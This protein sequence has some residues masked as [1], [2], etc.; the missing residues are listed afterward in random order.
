MLENDE[1]KKLTP[2]DMAAVLMAVDDMEG[3]KIFPVTNENIYKVFLIYKI[4][5][6]F[7]YYVIFLNIMKIFIM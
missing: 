4:A 7:S 5:I 3:M 6:F 2:E 1:E